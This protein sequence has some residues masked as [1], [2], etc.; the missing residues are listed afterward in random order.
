MR[1]YMNAGRRIN[2]NVARVL[3]E[4]TCPSRLDQYDFITGGGGV[5]T[6]NGFASKMLASVASDDQITK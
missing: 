6:A 4:R 5:G 3:L 2:N 1:G